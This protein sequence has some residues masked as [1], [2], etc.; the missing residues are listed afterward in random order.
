MLQSLGNGKA[1]LNKVYPSTAKIHYLQSRCLWRWS[2]F[3]WGMPLINNGASEHSTEPIWSISPTNTV[4]I[5]LET[6]Y[7]LPVCQ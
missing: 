4:G 2:G 7:L 5:T 6:N 3:V 1:L